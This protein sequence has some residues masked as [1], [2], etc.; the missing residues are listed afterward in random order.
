MLDR[1]EDQ[2]ADV[3]PGAGRKRLQDDVLD[4]AG[5]QLPRLGDEQQGDQPERDR[6]DGDKG[7][8]GD[9]RRIVRRR[10]VEVADDPAQR[11][12]PGPSGSRRTEDNRFVPWRATC[13]HEG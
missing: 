1:G 9:P 3:C 12:M 4:L 7:V 5:D 13:L 10:A 8:E 6:E 2:A 11:G